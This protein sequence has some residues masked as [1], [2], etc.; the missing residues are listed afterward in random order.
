MSDVAR[1]P[2]EQFAQA[3]AAKDFSRAASVLHPEI[4][5]RALTPNVT[6]KAFG[7]DEV[8][9]RVLRKWFEDSDEPEKLISFDARPFADREHVAYTIRGRNEN[10]PYVVEQQAYLTTENG[11]I[12]WMRVLCSGKR[13]P[14]TAG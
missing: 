6:W 10:G 5:F 4:D 3:L 7:P 8:V 12:A 9:A 1:S 11:Q 2:A 14:D 13:P